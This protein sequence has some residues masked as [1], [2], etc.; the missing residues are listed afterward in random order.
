[1]TDLEFAKRWAYT[2]QNDLDAHRE[3]YAADQLFSIEF[4]NVDD[5]LEDTITK[6]EEFHAGLE[7]FTNKD[8]TNGQGVQTI[9]VTEAIPGNGHV[10]IHWDWELRGADNYI[11]VPTAGKTLR[12]DGSTFLQFDDAG[13]II[14]DSSFL[15]E[16]PIL[17]ELGVPIIRPHYWK[18]DF[19]PA[20]LG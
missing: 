6:D 18:A 7:R 11:G 5:H 16:P 15:N 2:R 9:T 12:T 10:L 4:R 8:E 3:L 13:K 14:L 17:A 19:D 1:M 20:S